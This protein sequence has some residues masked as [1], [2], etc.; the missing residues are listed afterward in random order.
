MLKDTAVFDLIEA[1]HRR[2]KDGIEL[3]A[4]ENYVSDE[5]M[6]AMRTVRPTNMPKISRPSLLW[7]LSGGR[8]G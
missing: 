1:E 6:R 5:V 3:I 2:Q 4:S 7:R 8:S